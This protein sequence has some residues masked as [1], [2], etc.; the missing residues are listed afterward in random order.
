MATAIE[1]MDT[2]KA[3]SKYSGFNPDAENNYGYNGD[4]EGG[5]VVYNEKMK[6]IFWS[7]FPV[8]LFGPCEHNKIPLINLMLWLGGKVSTEEITT[9]I[10]EGLTDLDRYGYPFATGKD[11]IENA[12][13]VLRE[14]WALAGR[15]EDD[16]TITWAN[17][18]GVM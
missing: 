4:V 11:F 7:A 2:L 12:H 6:E 13:E 9:V 3:M 15:A 16:L 17:M 14:T 8:D 18:R 5:C 10:S 1:K